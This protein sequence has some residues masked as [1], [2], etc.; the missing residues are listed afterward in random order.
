LGWRLRIPGAPRRRKMGGKLVGFREGWGNGG[1]WTGD[2][3]GEWLDLD[4]REVSLVNCGGGQMA[5]PE[6]AVSV[7]RP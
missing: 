7:S 1:D 2:F 3:G 6:V 4:E 5:G